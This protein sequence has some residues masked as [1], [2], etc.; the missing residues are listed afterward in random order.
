MLIQ[1]ADKSII[2]NEVS[3]QLQ[4]KIYPNLSTPQT[5]NMYF[6]VSLNKG[7]FQSGISSSP[8]VQFRDST[9]LANIIDGIYVEE[10]PT[11]TGGVSSVS[12]ISAGYGYQYTPSVTILGDGTG[13]TAEAII[14][15][16]GTLRAINVLTSGNNYTSA[17]ATITPAAGDTTGTGASGVA[18]LEGQYGTLRTYYNNTNQVKTILN[19]SAGTVDYVNGVVTLNSFGPIEVD[20]PL[21]QFAITV[22]PTTTIV[23]SS[24]NKIITIDPFDPNAITVNVRTK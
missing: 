15:T 18:I 24:Q 8:A 16:N 6:G 11:S 23:S 5:Y 10:V 12:V 14:N 2:A 7:M 20:D 13:A 21:G 1:N 19:P 22:N 9:N 17:I 3:I 4:K